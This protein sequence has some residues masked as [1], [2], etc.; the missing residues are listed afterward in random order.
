MTSPA[1]YER[2][3]FVCLNERPADHP[4]GCCHALGGAEVHAHLKALVKQ[5]GLKGRVRA[6]K[7]GCLDFCEQG[8]TI[9]VYPDNVWYGGVKLEDAEEIV[10]EHL[11]AGRVVERL[12]IPERTLR[13]ESSV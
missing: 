8:V 5:R 6:N 7:A 9:V 10:D 2:H 12:R 1:P 11:V 3:L 13:R 4:R